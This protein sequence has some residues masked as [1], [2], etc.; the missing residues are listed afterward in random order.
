[1]LNNLFRILGLSLLLA[2]TPLLANTALPTPTHT[3]AKPLNG[4]V[5][6]VNSD[7]ITQAEFNLAIL[8]AESQAA[9]R[10]VNIKN[11]ADFKKQVL[12]QVIYQ[13]LQLQIAKKNGL[14]ASPKEVNNA[15]QRIIQNSGLSKNAFTEKL[16]R[17]GLPYASFREQ[18]KKQLITEKIQHQALGDKVRVTDAEVAAYRKAHHIANNHFEYHITDTVVPLPDNPSSAEVRT[19]KKTAYT[20]SKRMKQNAANTEADTRDLGW[21]TLEDLPELFVKPIQSMTVGATSAPIKA[22]N[23]FHIITLEGRRQNKKAVTNAQV[24]NLALQEKFL[25]ELQAWLKTLRESAYVHINKNAY[26]T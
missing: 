11:N 10:H 19:A 17:T 24:R 5:A 18:V 25:K 16:T 7:I 2:S 12:D 22:A 8:A 4:I 6:V 23:G 13:H 3:S 14:T 1:M 9:G 15:V 26:E 20:L 21:L